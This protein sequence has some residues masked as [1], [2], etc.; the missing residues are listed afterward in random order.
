MSFQP[1]ITTS[2]FIRSINHLS[3]KEFLTTQP[4]R[5]IRTGRPLFQGS[6][7]YSMYS[8]SSGTC[9]LGERDNIE[10]KLLNIININ[11]DQNVGSIS[12]ED[13]DK[14]KEKLKSLHLNPTTLSNRVDNLYV[15][16]ILT[17][18]IQPQFDIKTIGYEGKPAIDVCLDFINNNLDYFT[19]NSHLLTDPLKQLKTK[20]DIAWPAS[21]DLFSAL[22]QLTSSESDTQIRHLK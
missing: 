12:L 15:N 7:L 20:I 3:D 16:Q 8:L 4:K 13:L 2:D 22:S 11:G 1:N 5:D 19:R 21:K 9:P 18:L 17:N 10:E 14:F 6:E